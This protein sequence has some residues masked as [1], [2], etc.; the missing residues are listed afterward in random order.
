MKDYKKL[1]IEAYDRMAQNFSDTHFDSMY[2]SEFK[3]FTSLLK[4]NKVLEIGCGAGRDGELFIKNGYDYIG[5]DASSE[6]LKIAQ[7]RTPSGVFKQMDYYNLDFPANTFDGF[8]AS[9]SF[10]HVPKKDVSKLITEAKRILKSGGVGFISVKER[11]GVD[12]GLIGQ[13]IFGN[14]ARYFSFYS[15]G[16]FKDKLKEAGLEVVKITKIV[17]N[18][19]RKTLWFCYIVRKP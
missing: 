19:E 18:D 8:W 7:K 14:I 11:T 16:E 17:E 3:K 15:R 1:T 6:M 10:L 12:E 9:A 5:T 2:T 4:G 13:P